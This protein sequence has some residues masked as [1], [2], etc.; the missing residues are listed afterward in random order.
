M[1]YEA[2]IHNC[3]ENSAIFH[4]IC[5]EVGAIMNENC[6]GNSAAPHSLITAFV[7]IVKLFNN[8]SGILPDSDDLETL[9]AS[10][11][12]GSKQ[13]FGQ[14]SRISESKNTSATNIFSLFI[15]LIFNFLIYSK[16]INILHR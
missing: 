5:T 16:R 7:L 9:H 11:G 1:F 3:T 15:A 12:F 4:E 8:L 14:T 6:T 2:N 13:H 10:F